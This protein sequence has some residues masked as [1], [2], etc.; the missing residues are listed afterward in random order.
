MWAINNAENKD[1]ITVIDDS[2]YFIA[3]QAGE[4]L[5]A[6]QAVRKNE[7]GLIVGTKVIA[8]MGHSPVNLLGSLI[9][10]GL[11][12]LANNQQ[13]MGLNQASSPMQQFV[14][15]E[16]QKL[17]LQQMFSNAPESDKIRRIDQGYYDAKTQQIPKKW[18][19]RIG[20][21]DYDINCDIATMATGEKVSY[22]AIEDGYRPPRSNVE[23]LDR[24]VN[25]VRVKL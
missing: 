6:N 5:Q 4:K 10:S 14:M 18:Y 12:G 17:M 24:Q 19:D 20:A 16:Q 9:T 22:R 3:G 2:G 8:E 1:W 23:W 13:A 11:G 7:K 15:N 21:V 25:M